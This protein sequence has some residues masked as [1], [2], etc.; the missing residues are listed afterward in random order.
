MRRPRAHT[1]SPAVAR[2]LAPLHIPHRSHRQHPRRRC[3]RA[4]PPR[5]RGAVVC[6]AA[7][8]APPP[9]PPGRAPAAATPVVVTATAAPTAAVART[10]RR[11]AVPPASRRRWPSPTGPP[12][13]T[14][15][16]RASGVPTARPGGRP[17]WRMSSLG[18]ARNTRTR[19]V[20]RTA[21][22]WATRPHTAPADRRACVSQSVLVFILWPVRLSGRVARARLAAAAAARRCT[23]RRS[24]ATRRA[25]RAATGAAVGTPAAG[26]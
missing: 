7:G 25:Q 26:S 17:A 5:Q 14:S 9:A 19:R 22:S 10:L 24:D 11:L 8:T 2:R 23:A 6:P 3:A 15:T 20:Q 1:S 21:S 13:Y 16:T 18:G 12:P 4:P